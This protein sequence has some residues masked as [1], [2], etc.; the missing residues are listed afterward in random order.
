M[1]YIKFHFEALE[2]F[3]RL[4]GEI[5]VKCLSCR[6]PYYKTKTQV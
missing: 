6:L 4:F 5:L 1:S 2:Y 3:H